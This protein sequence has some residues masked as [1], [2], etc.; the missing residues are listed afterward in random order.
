MEAIINLIAIFSNE[1]KAKYASI[2]RQNA[3]TPT[4]LIRSKIG[5]Q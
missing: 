5:L 4:D 3:M 1:K 2:F